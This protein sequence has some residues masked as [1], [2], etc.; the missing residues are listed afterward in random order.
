LYELYTGTKVWG[1]GGEE[2]ANIYVNATT[3]TKLILTTE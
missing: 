2:G 3:K 1:G